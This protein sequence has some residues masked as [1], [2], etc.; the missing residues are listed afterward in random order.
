MSTKE[1]TCLLVGETSQGRGS[2]EREEALIPLI[3][4][5][6]YCQVKVKHKVSEVKSRYI[7]SLFMTR[8]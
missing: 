4:L 3:A 5:S 7:L 1:F 8:V 6:K 2:S